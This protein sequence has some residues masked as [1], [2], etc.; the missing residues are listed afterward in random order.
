VEV[1]WRQYLVLPPL[2]PAPEAGPNDCLVALSVSTTAG[3]HRQQPLHTC[4]SPSTIEGQQRVESTRL[5][6]TAPWQA[7]VNDWSVA[8]NGANGWSGHDPEKTFRRPDLAA[9]SCRSS[10]HAAPEGG[11]TAEGSAH[12]ASR[13]LQL[14]ARANQKNARTWCI[15]LD[16]ASPLAAKSF[17]AM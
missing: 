7:G 6:T 17:A 11:S 10:S 12:H 15:W 3:A 4:R 9:R 1:L 14:L 13:R 16:M 2:K 5:E 8:A